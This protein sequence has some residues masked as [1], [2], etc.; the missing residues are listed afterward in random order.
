MSRRS[1]GPVRRLLGIALRVVVGCA[2]AA[3]L[4]VGGTNLV[5]IMAT[6]GNVHTVSD[7]AD[8]D[9]DAVVVLGASVKADGTPSD[10]LQDRL[11]TA[12]SLYR[13]GAADAIIVSGD[14]RTSHYNESAA[15]KAYCMALGVPS[16]DIYEDHAGYSTYESMYRARHVFGAER[17]IVTTQAYHLYRAMFAAQ[18]LGMET[19]GVASDQGAY[20]NQ[21]MYSLREVVARTKDFFNTLLQTPVES[22]AETGPITLAHSGDET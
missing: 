19:R 7:L 11:E 10:I 3:L 18:G 21:R 20:D 2:L 8:F 5:T 12:V 22:A 17:I 6:R 1:K 4:V 13:V 15:M 16:E 14:N 9:A